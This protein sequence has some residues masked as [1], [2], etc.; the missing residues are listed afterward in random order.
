MQSCVVDTDS[1][2]L[3]DRTEE[4]RDIRDRIDGASECLKALHSKLASTLARASESPRDVAEK[5][6]S[7]VNNEIEKAV[8]KM[9]SEVKQQSQLLHAFWSDRLQRLVIEFRE[10]TIEHVNAVESGESVNWAINLIRAEKDELE[11]SGLAAEEAFW[12]LYACL[13]RVLIFRVHLQ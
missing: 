6:H 11:S 8:Q 4:Y 13:R 7:K 10:S 12:N 5:F 9:L 1:Q 2:G 3:E